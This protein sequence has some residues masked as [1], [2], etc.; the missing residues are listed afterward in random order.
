MVA[1]AC[2]LLQR[3]V[4]DCPE[5]GMNRRVAAPI[6]HSVSVPSISAEEYLVTYLVN[7]GLAKKEDLLAPENACRARAEVLM[8][9][10]L[11]LLQQAPR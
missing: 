5:H 1:A 9:L 4:Q 3:M 8:Q 7:M 11:R 2:F 6:F 10:V